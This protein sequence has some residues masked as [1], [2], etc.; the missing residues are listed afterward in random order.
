LKF[1]QIP[2]YTRVVKKVFFPQQ[3]DAPF[4]LVYTSENSSLIEDYP[5]LNLRRLDVRHV[6]VP[7]TRIPFTMLN[8]PLKKIYKDLGLLSFSSN[9]VYPKDKNLFFDLTPYF[10]KIDDTYKPT[11]Y[12]Q[13]AGF[14]IKNTVFKAFTSFPGNYKKVLIY[15]VDISQPINS[16]ANRKIFPLLKDL[17]E[18]KPSFDHMMLVVTDEGSARFRM[19]IKGKE[20]KFERVLNLL[21]RIKMVSSD[22]EKEEEV[23]QASD[24]VMNKVSKDLPDGEKSKVRSAIRSFLSKDEESLNRLTTGKISD[25]D[26]DRV[27]TASVLYGASGNLSKAKRIA[28][29]IPDKKLTTAVKAVSQQYADNLLET[30]KATSLSSSVYIQQLDIPRQIDN[31]TPEH[32]FEKRKIDFETNLRN[33]MINAFKVLERQDI[34]LKFDSLKIEDKPKRAG[35]ID[36]S[37]IARIIVVLIDKHGNKHKVRFN[38]PKIDPNTGTFRVNGKKKCLINQIVLNPISFPKVNQS[39]FESSYSTFHVYSKKMKKGPYLEIYMG[40][41][42]IPLIVLLSYAFG[43]DRS[44]KNYGIKYKIVDKRPG[45]DEVYTKVPS[46]YIVFE[47]LDTELKQELAE[48]FI[49]TKVDQYK[50]PEDFGSKKY[51]QELIL[52]LTG[53]INSTYHISLNLRNIV[54]PVATQV[55]INKQLPTN[56]EDVIKYMA[57]KAVE[58]Y[59]EDRTDL[60]NQRT[61]NSEIL[62]HLAQKQILAA[63]TE[64][65]GQYLSGNTDAKLAIPEGNVMSQFNKLEIVQDMEYAN[66]MEEMATITKISPVGKAVGGLP[67]KQAVQLDARNVHPTYFGNIDPLD[68]SEGGNIGITQQLAINAFI[69]SARG[70]FGEKPIDDKEASGM[71]ST[72]ACTIPFVSNNDG[73][74]I[75]MAVNQTKQT[76]PLKNPEPPVVQSGYE[77]VLANVLSDSFIKRSPCKGKVQTITSDYI[78][79]DCGGK[80]STVDI[81]PVSLKSGSGKNTLSTFNPTVV[82]GQSVKV[83]EVIAEGGGISSG[84][85]ALGRTLLTAYTHYKGYNFEDAIVISDRLVKEEKLTSLHGIEEEIYLD[86]NDSVAYIVDIGAMTKKGDPLLRKTIGD[87]DEL[88]G[89]SEEEDESEEIHDKQLIKKSPGGRVVDIEVFSNVEASKFPKLKDH[90]ARTTKRFRKPAEEKF[91]RR[92]VPVKGVIVRF[93]IEQHLHIQVGDKLCNRHGNKGILAL[94]EKAELMPRTPWGES[95]DIIMN[96]L[97][98]LGRMNLGQL[99]ELYC[100][101]ISKKLAELI[102]KSTSKTEIVKVI[103]AVMDKLDSSSNKEY[104]K[105]LVNNIQKLSDT[106]FKKMVSQIRTTGFVPIITPPFKSPSHTNIKDALKILGL[107]SAYHLKLPEF[108]VKTKQAVPVGYLYISKLE[109]LGSEKIHSRATGPM[110]GKT[111]QPTAGKRSE[112]GQRMGEGD[113]YAMLSY[114]C[115]LALSEFFG[116]L[117]DDVVTKN[118]IITDIVQ[119]GDAKWRPTKASPTKDLLNAYFVAMMLQEK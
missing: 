81:T 62:V 111:L 85:I 10:N 4:L 82:K 67:D 57:T 78:S 83:G 59:V 90:I 17:K 34:P 56:L 3:P 22:E 54:D 86:P 25:K 2:L 38:I 75:L 12:R 105:R 60:T 43:L 89:F 65:K 84:S 101:L 36:K 95:V 71:L 96:P 114:N 20:Y 55:L 61:R 109:H 15:S 14:L 100:G 30:H 21:K 63:Y 117:S 51:F 26:R 108:N 7:R 97:G 69:T 115:P 47:N 74:R 48:S 49:R 87:I 92:G 31:K 107:K 52:K 23:N 39:K 77:S 119:T 45:K 99:F 50:I 118:E 104:S 68:T 5:K 18:G 35:E 106:Q 113:T 1:D 110:V 88:L 70:M 29:R 24:N 44:L 91:T 64:Y 112:G 40:S 73:N 58:G 37:D 103:N 53:R 33:D 42:R 93:K 27:A 6:V 8:A 94:I 41:F 102:I 46:S 116:P 13:R 72:N 16:F 80:R 19:L 79:I 66:A 9:L 28:N 11:T 76:L 32:L 98:V